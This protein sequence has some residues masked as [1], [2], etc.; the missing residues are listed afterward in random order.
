[1]QRKGREQR[2]LLKYCREE[3]KYY[4]H[5]ENKW[6]DKNIEEFIYGGRRGG[7]QD[8]EKQTKRRILKATEKYF[9]DLYI[10]VEYIEIEIE[11]ALHFG[12]ICY[13]QLHKNRH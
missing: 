3:E 5:L 7:V 12:I 8:I 4:W 6:R 10:E 13:Q 9:D 11:I 2:R 1:M